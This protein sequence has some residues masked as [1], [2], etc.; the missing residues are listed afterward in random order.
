MSWLLLDASL[1][2]EGCV[3]LE[4][5]AAKQLRLMA[6]DAGKLYYGLYAN[7]FAS[8]LALLSF[9]TAGGILQRRDPAAWA[10]AIQGVFDRG[11]EMW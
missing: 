3:W 6:T 4:S 8:G 2:V 7:D 5:I 10:A 1:R 11:E 9:A